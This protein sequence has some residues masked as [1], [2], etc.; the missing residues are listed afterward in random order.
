MVGAASS[1]PRPAGAPRAPNLA[2]SCCTSDGVGAGQAL[3]VG[4]GRAGRGPTSRPGPGAPT[5][6]ATVRSGSQ[7]LS[8]QDR[9]SLSS[10]SV[11]VVSVAV[12]VTSSEVTGLRQRT[13]KLGVPVTAPVASPGGR[14]RRSRRATRQAFD[15]WVQAQ[16]AALDVVRQA[17][18]RAR[19]RRRPGRGLPLGDPA[20]PADPGLDRGALRP[21]APASSSTCRTSTRSC[22][23]T[24]PTCT[25]RSAS[26]TTRAPTGWSATAG[27][28][29]TSA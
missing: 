29:P 3:A 27:S 6:R 8:S 24:T 14:R 23:S 13:R 16:T 5:T 26:S 10:S 25:T 18:G 11:P 20:H 28:A 2:I 15:A 7:L 19:D 4:V 1:R 9:S 21:A 12:S 17:T 22:W